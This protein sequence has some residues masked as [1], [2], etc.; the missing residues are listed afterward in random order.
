M[1]SVP[2]EDH[3]DSV[4][5]DISS[6]IRAIT[7]ERHEIAAVNLKPRWQLY[8]GR[9]LPIKWMSGTGK[10]QAPDH[11][12]TAHTIIAAVPAYVKA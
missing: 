7:C 6:P 2:P 8:C 11:S 12:P 3:L 10:G 5:A 9:L 4:K 1:P